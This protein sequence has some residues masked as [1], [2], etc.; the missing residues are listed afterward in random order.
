[1]RLSVFFLFLFIAQAYA[2]ETYSQQTRLTLK[3][4]GAKVI[5]VLN[6]IEDESEFFFLFNQKLVNVER[7][8][9]VNVVNENV[10]KILNGLFE[11]TNVH[12]LVKDRQIILTTSTNLSESDQGQQKTVSGKV[13][14]Q[15]GVSIAGASVVVKGTTTG[16][17]TNNEGSFSLLLPVNAKVLVFSFVGMKTQEMPIGAKS[18]FNIILIE[19]MIGLDEVVAIGYGTT[20]KRKTVSAIST[21][22]T[23]KLQNIPVPTMG[24][25]LA[26]RTSGIIVTTSGGGPGKKPVISVRGGGT[27][28]VVIDGIVSSMTDFQNLNA[29]DI[30]S[31][32]ILKDA[33]GAAIYGARGGNGIIAITTKRGEAGKMRINYDYSMNLAQPSILPSKLGSY[34][35]AILTNEGR[36]NDGQAAAYAPDIVQKYKDQSDPFNYPNT[37]WQKAVLKTFAPTSRHDLTIN[38]GNDKTKYFASVSYY[39]QG[40]LYKFNTNWL[41]R[42]NYRLSLTNNFDKIGLTANVNIYGVLEKTRIP[43]S[44]YGS[45]Y[46]YTWGHIQNQGPMSIAYTDKGLYSGNGDHPLVEIDPNSGYDLQESRNVNGIID[47]A[48]NVPGVN[49][50]K[51]KAINHYRLDNSFGR[52]WNATADQYPLGSTTPITHNAPRLAAS[53]GSGYSYTNQVYADYNNVF[54]KVHSIAATFGYERTY[55]RAESINATRVGYQL[56]FDQFIAGPTLNSTNGG[57]ASESARAGYIGR[58]RYDYKSKYFIEGS[59]R[60]DGSDWFPKDNR[61]GT[62]WSGSAGWLLSEEAFMKPLIDKNIVNFLKL[63][64][65]FG[66]VGLDGSDAGI[67]RFQYIPGYNIV[68]RGYLVNN[69]FVQGFTEGPLVSPDLTWYTQKSRNIGFDFTSL[70]SKLSGSFDYFYIETTGMLAS[71]SGTLYTDPLGISLPTRKSNGKYRRGGFEI[72]LSYK[73]NLGDL[74]YEIGGNLTRFDQLWEV[75][76]NEDAATLKNP[77]TRTTQQTGYYGIGYN[78]LGYYVSAQDVMNSPKLVAATNL[79]PGDIKYADNNGDGQIDSNDQRRI[80]KNS[81]PRINYGINLDFR[82]KAWFLYT[83]IQGS[84]NKNSYPGD[85]IQN[86]TVYPFQKDYWTPTNTNGSYPRLMSSGSYNSNNNY[87][88]SDY[89]LVN[90]RYIRLKSIQLGYDM[91]Q[92]LL[93]TSL[94]FVSEFS[95]VLSGSNLFTISEALSRYKMDPEVGSNNNYDYPTERIYSLT[96]RIGF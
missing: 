25:M 57:S 83:L 19:D 47:L 27:P 38:G 77:Y 22:Q 86:G 78:N 12:Y 70:K 51:I 75:N 71:L 96:V 85:V 73:N 23:E 52:Q 46:Y 45:G 18:E 41:K 87:A 91:K 5:D 74:Q 60:R 61:W 84:G 58:L 29:S 21:I 90:S 3:M 94:P 20:S 6:R 59:F 82:Y 67:S 40:T 81:F 55:G 11:D 88:T 28:L 39:D 80:G 32:S 10:E 95:L 50:L 13:T 35:R 44:Q 36:I 54:A 76:P 89:W 53:A 49:G 17:T 79:V 68:E 4:Q 72:N 43:A 31:F 65:S 34:D 48:W 56:L 15:S 69:S 33:E 9:N 16:V 62:F 8:V 93:K 92:G 24:D 42:Y 26:G 37:D 66:T 30:E 1:M 64:G 14:D 2:A 7:Q 63:R